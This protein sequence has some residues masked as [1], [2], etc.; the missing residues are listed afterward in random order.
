MA[1]KVQPDTSKFRAQL[2]NDLNKI[3]QNL[4]AVVGVAADARG[5]RQDLTR[6]VDRASAG[7]SATVGAA[8]G[9]RVSAMR[10][11]LLA[12]VTRAQA[13]VSAEI[14][15]RFDT[16]RLAELGKSLG[17]GGGGSPGKI[18]ANLTRSIAALAALGGSVQTITGLTAA[19]S[20]LAPAALLLPGV[21]AAAGAGFAALKIGMSGV[22][23]AL[24]GDAEAM[25]KLAPAARE[26]VAAIRGMQPAWDGLKS[27]VQGALFE[28]LAEP[29]RQLGATY[30]PLLK[31][32]LTGIGGGLNEI[33]RGALAATNNEFFRGDVVQILSSTEAMFR[34]MRNSLG[35]LLSGFTGLAAVGST[36]LPALGNAVSDVSARFKQWVDEGIETG[37]IEALIDNAIQGFR[38][39]AGIVGNVGS[40][41][42]S[43]FSGLSAGNGAATSFLGS[44]RETTAAVAEF[45][46][47]VQ[48]QEALGALG[49]T[50]RVTGEVVRT[51]LLTALQQLA[52]VIVAAGP[53]F[54]TMAQTLG[55]VLVGALQTLGPMLTGFATFL[56]NN[57]PLVQALTVGLVGAAGALKILGPLVSGI[58]AVIRAW[59]I[60]QGILNI[61]LAAN[62][63]GLVVIAI[64]ALVAAIVYAWNNSERFR[65]IVL[66]VWAAVK[67][68]I[69]TAVD[70]I[71]GIL[72][73]FG[74]LPGLIAGWFGQAK[75]WAVRK[76]TELVDWV[77]GIPGRILGALGNLGS[78]LLDSGRSLVSGLLNG[79]KNAWNSVVDWVKGGLSR[80][81]GLFPFS[82]AKWGPFSGSGY[83]T[84][85]GK[86]LTRDFGESIRKGM[87]GVAQIARDSMSGIHDV[88]SEP[89]DVGINARMDAQLATLPSGS[90][91]ADVRSAVTADGFGSLDEKVADAVERALSTWEWKMND[92]AVTKAVNKR[93]TAQRRR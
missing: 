54:Q 64:A 33:A 15:V 66:A 63:I 37:R 30:L 80:L 57:L 83:T 40:I 91:S 62:P 42:D 36:Y 46:A 17:G 74:Q 45:M 85:S 51:V 19:L 14:P 39:L 49:E 88:L 44:I 6:S 34:N 59:S 78:L 1:V 27:S 61:V 2:R 10:A 21:L 55:G 68:A 81:R 72:S 25:A 7:L 9:G 13:G 53:A 22:S 84:H 69:S 60:A 86:A 82:P 11:T 5:L 77:R 35:N 43:L 28:N 48:A 90:Y 24:S 73:W 29:I 38:D 76:F 31:T 47:S 12:L 16:R 70:T 93:N 58:T 79:I 65:E 26:T 89:I 50:L 75:D 4:R 71:K 87:R 8:F 23:D 32:G 92:Q 20:Q 3:T 52:P 67:S 18:L 56:S 41:L